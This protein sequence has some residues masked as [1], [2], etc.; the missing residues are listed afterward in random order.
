MSDCSD[1]GKTINRR[2]LRVSFRPASAVSSSAHRSSPTQSSTGSSSGHQTILK[3]DNV[4]A[5]SLF[6]RAFEI[7][8]N[9]TGRDGEANVGA[10]RRPRRRPQSPAMGFDDRSADRKPDAKTVGF[11]GEERLKHIFCDG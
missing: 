5:R 7:G 3:D 8:P 10:K 1:S 6:Q 11:R 4:E 2:Q 9:E